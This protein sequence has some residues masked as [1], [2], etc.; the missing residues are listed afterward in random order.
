MDAFKSLDIFSESPSVKI[1]GKTKLKTKF[2]AFIG[3]L[4]ISSLITG[5]T[6]I[7]NDYFSLLSYN[8]KSYIDNSIRPDI[9]LSKIKLGFTLTDGI[10][11][12]FSERDRL[13]SIKATFWDIYIPQLGDN[14]NTTK[15]VQISDIPIIKFNEYKNKLL[16]NETLKFTELIDP[17][18]FV[19]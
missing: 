7:L 5:I 2:G 11:N 12:P 19:F 6:I 8:F 1:D 4:T 13:F 17:F 9:D 14:Y 15:K 10:G 3:F 18:F 16:P